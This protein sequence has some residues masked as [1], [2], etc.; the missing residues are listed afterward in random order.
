MESAS[1]RSFTLSACAL[2]ALAASPALGAFQIH[3]TGMNLYYDGT[4][5]RDAGSGAGGVA[6]PA[7]GDALTTVDFFEDGVLI[8]S[9]DSNVT[10]DAYIPDVAGMSGAAN[11]VD[12]Q[13]T[14][15]NPGFFD[16]LIGTSPLASEFLLLDLGSVSLTYMDIAGQSRFLFGAAVVDVYSD[17][18][19]FGI[20]LDGPVTVS[21]STQVSNVSVIGGT[22]LGFDAIGTGEITGVPAP[23]SALTLGGLLAAGLRRRRTA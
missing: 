21:F 18:L 5:I 12:V 2:V 19:P 14:P 7:D 23:A 17:N 3:I 8:G 22:I 4:A 11:T 16:L 1:I 9:L 6:D 20:A 10:L 15:G 13:T